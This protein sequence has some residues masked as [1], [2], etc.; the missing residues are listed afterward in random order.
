[1]IRIFIDG[2]AGATGLTLEE[3]LAA[4]PGTEIL[5]PDE[6]FRKDMETRRAYLNQ[7]DVAFLC[8]PDAAAREAA[9]MLT[10]PET[11]LIDA[12]TAHR[13]APG[14]AYGFPELSESHYQAL[15]TANRITVPGCHASGFIA[16]VYPLV[17][18]GFIGTGETLRCH[19]LT[20][21]SGGGR[22]MIDAYETGD[23]PSAAKLYAL[24]LSHKH[25]P[26]MRHVCGLINP[27]VFLP[28]VTAARQG[29]VVTVP[30][31]ADARAVWTYLNHYYR[32]PGAVSVMPFNGTD[33][34][35]LEGMN[36]TN[37]M[38]LYVFGCETQTVLAARFDNLGKGSAG[39][40]LQCMK[41]RM[42]LCG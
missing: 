33:T 3:K 27:P 5:K 15:R 34:L 17:K 11:V 13:T 20:G 1:M 41:V 22:V 19:S 6:N 2:M 29:M 39:A 28:V 24:D 9:G 42:G 18:G 37:E 31:D 12:S 21:Y 38:E 10:N 23:P 7:A 4:L 35:T 30:L 25:L 32:K 8:L 36:H 14:W 26:E 16:L 40:A